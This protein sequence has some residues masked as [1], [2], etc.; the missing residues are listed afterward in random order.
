MAR[1]LRVEERHAQPLHGRRLS[2]PRQEQHHKR[3]FS[4][5]P[6]IR[7]SSPPKT[8]ARRRWNTCLSAWRAVSP[9]VS[10]LWRS[11]ATSSCVRSRRRSKAGWTSRASSASTAT[12]ATASTAS[13]SATRSMPM[14]ARRDRGAGGAVAEALGGLRHR[15]QSDERHRRG[16]LSRRSARRTGG[17]PVRTVTTVDHRRGPCRPGDEPAPHRA[18]DRPCGARARRGGELLAHRA[19]G[20]AAP[21]HAQLAEPAARL[22]ATTATIRTDTWRVP[23]IIDL[24]RPLC[25]RSRR[26]CRRTRR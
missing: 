4:S 20:F 15:H 25:A 13:R 17:T 8:T 5:K 3:T 22:S 18:L 1:H 7:K 16:E 10:P 6:I 2:R 19:L 26:R 12:C 9:P 11:T 24:H 14:P 23:E 21:A